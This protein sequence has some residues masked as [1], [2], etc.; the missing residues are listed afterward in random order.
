MREERAIN[1]Y[2]E[3]EYEMRAQLRYSGPTRDARFS[4]YTKSTAIDAIKLGY[5][6]RI[7]ATR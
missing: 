3:I 5:D 4:T 2:G 7:R 6:R 1:S